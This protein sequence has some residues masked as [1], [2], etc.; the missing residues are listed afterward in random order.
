MIE[1]TWGRISLNHRHGNDYIY[2][3]GVFV[4]IQ[5]LEVLIW[6]AVSSSAACRHIDGGGARR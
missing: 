1:R 4:T 5:F 6:R 3:P 2:G